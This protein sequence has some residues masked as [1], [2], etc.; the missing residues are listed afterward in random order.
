[1]SIYNQAA[2]LDPFF[3]NS[4]EDLS[5]PSNLPSV[6]GSWYLVVYPIA[7]KKKTQGGII[8]SDQTYDSLATLTSVGIVVSKGEL[9]YKHAKFQDPET[10]EFYHWAELGSIIM[11][12]RSLSGVEQFEIEGK[13]LFILP[14][15]AVMCSVNHP[16][17]I[18]PLYTYSEEELAEFKQQIQDF[19][20]KV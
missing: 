20:A 7:P 12:K 3:D 15:S 8:L 6:K 16:S 4:N 19:N 13:K 18:D 9:A 14:D 5:L 1:M 11:F 17:I 10:K 2:T